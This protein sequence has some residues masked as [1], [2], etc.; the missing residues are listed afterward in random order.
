MIKPSQAK[1]R[2]S[3]IPLGQQRQFTG[4]VDK[5]FC[6]K[7][8][9]KVMLILEHGLVCNKEYHSEKCFTNILI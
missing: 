8:I 3:M 6:I 4:L 2:S 7:N 5:L 1:L 9:Q